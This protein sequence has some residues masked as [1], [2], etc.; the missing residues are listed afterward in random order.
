MLC[1]FAGVCWGVQ[2]CVAGVLCGLGFVVC[3][4]VIGWFGVFWRRGERCAVDN[5]VYSTG[6][7]VPGTFQLLIKGKALIGEAEVLAGRAAAAFYPAVVH[8]S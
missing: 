6:H 4:C 7:F 5:A 3:V 1:V 8:H 2:V